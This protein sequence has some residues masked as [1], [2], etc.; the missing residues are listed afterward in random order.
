MLAGWD[1][2][3]REPYK[4]QALL[5]NFMFIICFNFNNNLARLLAINCSCKFT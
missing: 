1:I 5:I 3:Y 4:S 2:I